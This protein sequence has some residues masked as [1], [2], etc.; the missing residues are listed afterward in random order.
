MNCIRYDRLVKDGFL[1][2]N[3]GRFQAALA[4]MEKSSITRPAILP[5]KA[6][7]SPG[8][9]LPPYLRKTQAPGPRCNPMPPNSPGSTPKLVQRHNVRAPKESLQRDDLDATKGDYFERAICLR[10]RVDIP[11]ERY[12]L[13][14]KN[15]SNRIKKLDQSLADIILNCIRTV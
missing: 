8:S 13:I 3:R 1:K 12:D 15:A 11:T 5:F 14:Q 9:S 4:K 7:R 6:L 10:L 2:G